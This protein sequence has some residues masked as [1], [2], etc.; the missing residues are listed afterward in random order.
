MAFRQME[1]SQR[2]ISYTQFLESVEQGMVKT[3]HLEGRDIKGK[4]SIWRNFE[5]VVVWFSYDEDL[6]NELLKYNVE[7]T[8]EKMRNLRSLGYVSIRVSRCC[9]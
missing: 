9:C 8:G 3:V 2:Q 1:C 5:S 4:L 6:I 7:M